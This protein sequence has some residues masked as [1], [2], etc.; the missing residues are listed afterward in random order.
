MKIKKKKTE[1]ERQTVLCLSE[2]HSST[3]FATFL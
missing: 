2:R 1:L 3:R